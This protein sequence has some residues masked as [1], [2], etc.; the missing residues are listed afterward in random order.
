[1]AESQFPRLADWWRGGGSVSGTD[2]VFTG[3][4]STTPYETTAQ[5]VGN[6]RWTV[7]VEYT[8]TQAT[9]LAIRQNKLKAAANNMGA[10]QVF[11]TNLDLSVG[12]HLTTSI[13]LSLDL[14]QEYWTPSLG[15]SGPVTIHSVS[16]YGTPGLFDDGYLRVRSVATSVGNSG[17][18]PALSAESK[19]GDTVLLFLASQF[20]NTKTRPEGKWDVTYSANAGSGRSGLI[21]RAVVTDPAQ[22]QNVQFVPKGGESNARERVV[23]LVVANGWTNWPREWGPEK[24]SPYPQTAITF[25]AGQSHGGAGVAWEDWR[26]DPRASWTAGDVTPAA[27]WSSLR[28]EART[29]ALPEAATA[30]GWASV[31]IG[32]RLPPAGGGGQ[33]EEPV[34]QPVELHG[35]GPA[36]VSV[37]EPP[38]V[39]PAKIGVMPGGY[40][41]I[42]EMMGTSGFL[43]AHRGGSG[44]WPEMSMKAYTNSVAYGAKALEVSTHKTQDGVWVLCHDQNLKRVD[45]T[46]P[47]TTLA[48]MT[49]AEVQKYRTVGEP[50]V[51]IE[52]YLEAYGE[53]HVTI[54]DPK[55]SALQWSELALML[56]SNAKDHVIWKS[57]GDATWLANQWRAAG[58]KCWGYAYEQHAASG[59]LAKWAPSWDYIGYPW[60]ASE[61][62]WRIVTGLG[63]PVWAHICPSKA[64]YDQGLARG[65]VGC[66]VSGIADVL[67]TSTV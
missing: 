18:I 32:G 55:Y 33:V 25:F 50:F 11:R 17:N 35:V 60:E 28:V 2:V 13:N 29:D 58:W 45:S 19:V 4:T 64:A 65:A 8:A 16:V 39:V 20:G 24:P 49:W 62:N 38:T 27:S 14:A 67:K 63:K 12:E 66:M 52:E 51:R 5:K 26:T 43:I 37:Y 42:S 3:V 41:S 47:E 61:E 57:A 9:R 40:S 15:I 59:D 23:M 46:A 6:G 21:A 1:M 36:R 48:Q 7:E 44:S 34:G 22:T 30:M 56:P 31:S 53:S 54:L 10:G